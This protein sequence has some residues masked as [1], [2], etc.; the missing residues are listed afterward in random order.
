MT[1]RKIGPMRGFIIILTLILLALLGWWAYCHFFGKSGPAEV[2][3][4]M[5]PPP[6]PPVIDSRDDD[7]FDQDQALVDYRDGFEP[8][9]CNW[10][11]DHMPR[12]DVTYQPGVDVHGHAVVPADLNGGFQMDLPRTVEASVSR[13]LL[14]HPNLRQQTPFAMVEI[15]LK[16]GAVSINGQSLDDAEHEAL[17]A[18]CEEINDAR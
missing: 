8:A 3:I 7:T 14:R 6:Q 10:L 18:Y 15:D 11:V 2:V 12:P 17:L 13:R 16:T 4:T 9:D 1:A 5:D